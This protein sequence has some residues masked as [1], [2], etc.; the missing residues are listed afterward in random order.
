MARA[1]LYDSPGEPLDVLRLE[2]QDP[3]HDG[4]PGADE[5]AIEMIL[6]GFM[7]AQMGND[8]ACAHPCD[9][10]PQS[11]APINPSDINT[12]QGKYPLMPQLPKGV[13]GHEGVGR[14]AAV[15]SGVSVVSA[16]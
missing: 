5:I 1:L 14:V 16:V 11:Q 9:H 12:V 3:K 6:V 13:P 15:G 2:Q 7:S 4:A 8:R 10:I